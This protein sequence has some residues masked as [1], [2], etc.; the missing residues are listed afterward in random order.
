MPNTKPTGTWLTICRLAE[1]EPDTTESDR[2]IC[3]RLW[4][5]GHTAWKFHHVT[6]A[7]RYYEASHRDPDR[8]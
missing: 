5:R 4:L 1:I 2:A 6:D 8:G 3:D 7:R